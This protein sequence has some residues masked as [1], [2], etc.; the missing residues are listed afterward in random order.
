MTVVRLFRPVE[1][2]AAISKR[3]KTIDEA[4]DML[5]VSRS[6]LYGLMRLGVLNYVKFRR[7]RY[8]RDEDIRNVVPKLFELRNQDR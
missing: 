1:R 8:I 7:E 6:Y 2:P 3:Y 4:C 5:G